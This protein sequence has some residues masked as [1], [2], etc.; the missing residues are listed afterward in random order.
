MRQ[1]GVPQLDAVVDVVVKFRESMLDDIFQVRLS[2]RSFQ[3]C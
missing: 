1:G 3:T 2:L